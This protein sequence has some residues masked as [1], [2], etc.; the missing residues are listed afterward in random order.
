MSPRCSVLSNMAGKIS[1]SVPLWWS[2]LI[3][4]RGHTQKCSLH[5]TLWR[6]KPWDAGMC[7]F[8]F[9]P[10]RYCPTHLPSSLYTGLWASFRRLGWPLHG[11][12]WFLL[13]LPRNSLHEWKTQK[14]PT[15]GLFFF[16]LMTIW[17]RF[18]LY[19]I[20]LNS[21]T[22]K[23]ILLCKSLWILT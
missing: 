14:F 18:T 11:H 12:H 16:F 3:K 7:T 22:V 23:L 10:P 20:F 13:F 17:E 2:C 6:N 8:F 19:C 1:S 5:I 21:H 4:H 15:P 9:F